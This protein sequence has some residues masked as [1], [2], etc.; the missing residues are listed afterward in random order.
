MKSATLPSFW[1]G[2]RQL[3]D[4]VRLNTRKAYRLGQKTHFIRLCI[5]NVLIRKKQFGL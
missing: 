2:Y 4:E 3:N 1:A 5:S